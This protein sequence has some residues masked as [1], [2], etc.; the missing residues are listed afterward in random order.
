MNIFSVI[1]GVLIASFFG[2]ALWAG[3]ASGNMPSVFRSLDD[4]RRDEAPIAF[5]ILGGIY[6]SLACF[7]VVL[8]ATGWGR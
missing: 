6:M 3:F 4:V 7:G 5:R 8:A 2:I 1:V